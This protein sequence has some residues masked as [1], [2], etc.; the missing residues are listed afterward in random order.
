[1]STILSTLKKLNEECKNK[2]NKI[3]IIKINK[4]ILFEQN[5]TKGNLRLENGEVV[6]GSPLDNSFKKSFPSIRHFYAFIT[7]NPLRKTLDFHQFEQKE[8]KEMMEEC[9]DLESPPI[10]PQTFEIYP[11]PPQGVWIKPLKYILTLHKG[12]GKN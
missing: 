5:K 6:L 2:N 1:M 11:N 10:I 7:N 3:Y 9:E 8:R 4:T 12:F